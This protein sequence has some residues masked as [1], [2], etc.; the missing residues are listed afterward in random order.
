MLLRIMIVRE[1]DVK[2]AHEIRHIPLYIETY[3][4][5]RSS[6]CHCWITLQVLELLA[7]ML[8]LMKFSL[9]SYTPCRHLWPMNYTGVTSNQ[10]QSLQM[11]DSNTKRLSQDVKPISFCSHCLGKF[12]FYLQKEANIQKLY[13][14]D[15]H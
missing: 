6:I 10:W 7:P 9:L 5:S 8:M 13:A 15:R 1:N 14:R 4:I 11:R 2:R 12:V 3:E